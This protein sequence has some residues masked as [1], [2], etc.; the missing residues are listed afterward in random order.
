M[1]TIYFVN[2]LWAGMI[3]TNSNNKTTIRYV[4]KKEYVVT[5][6]S[7]QELSNTYH[8]HKFIMNSLN[9]QFNN[10]DVYIKETIDRC[11]YI[12]TVCRIELATRFNGV[13]LDWIP[14]DEIDARFYA[15]QNTRKI[16]VE[17]KGKHSEMDWS[18]L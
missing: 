16:L 5:L 17:K 3:R 15:H 7:Q 6:M 9:G 4:D 12:N 18:N 10:Q 2:V 14:Y 11:T 13:L 8:R 1:A